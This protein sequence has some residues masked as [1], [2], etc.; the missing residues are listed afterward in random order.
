MI[1]STPVLVRE[2]TNQKKQM[3]FNAMRG[4][5]PWLLAILPMAIGNSSHGYRQHTL[6]SDGGSNPELR[7]QRPT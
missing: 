4:G 5:L 7:F 6:C 1:S 2:K 3:P